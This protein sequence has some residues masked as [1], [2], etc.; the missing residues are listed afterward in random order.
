LLIYVHLYKNKHDMN[1]SVFL[2]LKLES[3]IGSNIGAILW[4]SV[5]NILQAVNEEWDPGHYE[6]ANKHKDDGYYPHHHATLVG[7][8]SCHL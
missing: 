4:A 7:H 2:C 8:H 1:V 5:Y 6:E 3:F